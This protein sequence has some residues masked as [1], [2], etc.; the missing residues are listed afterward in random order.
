MFQCDGLP[1]ARSLSPRQTPSLATPVA[2][3]AS[4]TGLTLAREAT[5]AASS[6]VLWARYLAGLRVVLIAHA[7]WV[8]VVE[9]DC[10]QHPLESSTLTASETIDQLDAYRRAPTSRLAL[11]ISS[12][13]Q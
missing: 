10:E 9:A 4:W 12:K 5:A 11:Q 6:D 3:L 8:L 7:V 2:N 13:R 1:F